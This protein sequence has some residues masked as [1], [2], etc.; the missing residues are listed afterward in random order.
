ME[1]FSYTRSRV[2]VDVLAFWF[3][4]QLRYKRHTARAGL[5]STPWSVL[6]AGD[7]FLL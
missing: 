1:F 3:I 6:P 5:V 2:E 4:K 7:L